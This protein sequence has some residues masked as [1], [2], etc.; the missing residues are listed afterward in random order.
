MTLI[1]RYRA[2]SLAPATHDSLLE[3]ARRV[4]GDGLAGV[5]AEFCFYIDADRDLGP[6]DLRMLDWLLAETFEPEK[7][8]D[9][10][11]LDEAHGAV[12][13]VGPRMTFT[14]AWSTNAVS[15]CRA[16]GPCVPGVA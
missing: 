2:F 16:C 9:T 10:T 5:D 14:T 6:A 11:F 13:E 4:L 3:S 15:I 7:Y 12:L 1:R 8:G